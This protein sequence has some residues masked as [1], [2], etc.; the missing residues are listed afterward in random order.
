MQRCE[1]HLFLALNKP[2]MSVR[3]YMSSL[4]FMMTLTGSIPALYGQSSSIHEDFLSFYFDHD[5][6][7][8]TEA[9]QKIDKLI[10]QL[11]KKERSEQND[12][13][14][15]RTIFYKTHRKILRS[16]SP[17]ASMDETIENGTYGCLTGTVVY[18][19]LLSHFNFNYEIVELP[20]HVFLKVKLADQNVYF[21]S[22]LANDGFITNENHFKFKRTSSSNHNT[23]WLQ[24]ISEKTQMVE[25]AKPFKIIDL[26]ELR[27]LQHFNEAVKLYKVKAYQESISHAIIAFYQYPTEKNEMLTRFVL[28]RILTDHKLDDLEKRALVN[29]FETQLSF[30]RHKVFQ[31]KLTPTL[32]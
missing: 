8:A 19:L 25:Q 3:K 1:V 11:E 2:S 28:N 29:N 20:N 10:L 24:V 22:T 9:F 12:L 16:Y 7:P 5:S 15:L 23:N 17:M 6:T 31:A 30:N 32:E 13:R 14:F 18:A 27:G 26:K 4:I 21:E